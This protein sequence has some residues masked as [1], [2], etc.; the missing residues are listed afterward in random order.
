MRALLA[1]HPVYVV[2]PRQ[3]AGRGVEGE[4]VSFVVQT[5]GAVGE[6]RKGSGM[7]GGYPRP[8]D[9]VVKENCGHTVISVEWSALRRT[10]DEETMDGFGRGTVGPGVW[11]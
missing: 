6:D 8:R 3:L 1:L 5:A 4:D 2:T 9:L 7:R 10:F 11:L